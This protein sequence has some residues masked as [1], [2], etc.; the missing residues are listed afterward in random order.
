MMDHKGGLMPLI[1]LQTSVKIT[2][3]PAI[4][5]ELSKAGSLCTG[6]PENYFQVIVEDD[7]VISMAGKITESAFIDMRSIGETEIN[8]NNKL[9]SEFCRILKEKL[10]IDPVKVYMNFTGFS[11]ENWGVASKTYAEIL[12]GNK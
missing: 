8:T 10:N 11:T 2:D 12:K 7:A 5:L 1:K 3:K 9:S 4:A 6:K